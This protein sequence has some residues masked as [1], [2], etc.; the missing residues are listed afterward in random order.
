LTEVARAGSGELSRALRLLEEGPRGGRPLP[1]GI[2][3]RLR[4][5]VA[6]GGL[7]VLVARSG[8][9]V[10]GALILAYR[11]SVVSGAVFASIE[12]LYVG[13]RHRRRGIGSALLN[14]AGERCR[15]RG[16]SYLEV[17]ADG[18][19]AQGFYAARGFAGEPGVRVMSRSLPFA[20]GGRE[21]PAPRR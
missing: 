2:E 21:A 11:T 4:R 3:A 16:V 19:A 8:E 13:P 7:E 15:E 14:A 9:D 1:G 5:E 10:V 20:R 12:E 18:G 6:A 17:Q